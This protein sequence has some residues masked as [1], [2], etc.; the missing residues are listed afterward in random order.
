MLSMSSF[1]SVTFGSFKHSFQKHSFSSFFKEA[2][3]VVFRLILEVL[4]LRVDKLG[5]TIQ[6][7][8]LIKIWQ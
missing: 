3:D 4:I 1:I 6:L 8:E 5:A 2:L 7:P